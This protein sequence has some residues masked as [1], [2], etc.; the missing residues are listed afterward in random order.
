M[1]ITTVHYR[2]IGEGS[3][4]EWSGLFSIKTA[5]VVL[6]LS[7]Q[8]QTFI[9]WHNVERIDQTITQASSYAPNELQRKKLTGMMT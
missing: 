7:E 9:P 3:K 1:E 6:V 4:K 2:S 5:G 8:S